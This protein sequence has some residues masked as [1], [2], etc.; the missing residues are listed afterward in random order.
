MMMGLLVLGCTG[1]VVLLHGFH[2]FFHVLSH[3]MAVRSLSFLGV[4]GW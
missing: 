1:M 2:F 4:V 3:Q